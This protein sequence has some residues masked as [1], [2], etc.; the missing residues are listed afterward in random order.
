[1]PQA[2]LNLRHTTPKDYFVNYAS[3]QDLASS[4]E[5]GYRPCHPGSLELYSLVEKG[6][7]LD[8][9]SNDPTTAEVPERLKVVEDLGKQGNRESK[10]L[11]R[12]VQKTIRST[13]ASYENG[14]SL[15]TVISDLMS[16][17]NVMIDYPGGELGPQDRWIHFHAAMNLIKMM[18]PVC[19]AFADECWSLITYRK[20][21]WRERAFMGI[22]TRGFS[23]TGAPYHHSLVRE[24][25]YPEEDGTLEMLTDDTLTCSVQ[26]N[27]KLKC[28]VELDKPDSSLRGQAVHDWIV[29]EVLSSPEWKEKVGQKVDVSAAKKVIVVKGGKLVNFVL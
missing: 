3:E 23:T 28:V 17:T 9:V 25:P 14:Y 26:I 11:W 20:P 8:Y 12:A 4:L 29:S 27:G 7:I 21:T 18:A 5:P 1:V 13:T 16:L 6:K 24:W 10:K 22:A 2:V 19:P 15:N